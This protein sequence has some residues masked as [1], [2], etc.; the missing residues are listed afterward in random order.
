MLKLIKDVWAFLN[1]DVTK[2]GVVKS[3]VKV[4]DDNSYLSS[5]LQKNTT[6][7]YEKMGIASI[8][9]RTSEGFRVYMSDTYKDFTN[10]DEAMKWF[11]IKVIYTLEFD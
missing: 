7:V 4:K 3:L 9:E 2:F 11:N 8:F 1:T 10:L 5:A 6:I